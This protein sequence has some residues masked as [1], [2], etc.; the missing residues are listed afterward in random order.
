MPFRVVFGSILARFWSPLGSLWAPCGLF[1]EAF[2]VRWASVGS[3][4]DVQRAKRMPR[5]ASH[6]IFVPYSRILL[7]F[8]NGFHNFS[9]IVLFCSLIRVWGHFWM[10]REQ[11][12]F[13]KGS[14]MLF[15]CYILG[16]YIFCCNCFHNWE[17]GRGCAAGA[18]EDH[19]TCNAVFQ[20]IWMS[21]GSSSQNFQ[22]Y[23]NLK[24]ASRSLL[25]QVP[26]TFMLFLIPPFKNQHLQEK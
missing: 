15:S 2:G 19:L 14:L 17:R 18:G 21:L 7:F 9:C 23:P 5:R 22:V 8:C 1:W 4:L 12:G 13:T 26:R 16:F 24:R 20:K 25:R 10:S 11:Q 3:F 6:V